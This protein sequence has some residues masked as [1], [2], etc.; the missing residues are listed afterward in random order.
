MKKIIPYVLLTTL[1]ACQNKAPETVMSKTLT[2]KDSSELSIPIVGSRDTIN[3]TVADGLKQGHWIEFK[4]SM[5]LGGPKVR[6]GN[7]KNSK[8]IGEWL[9]YGERQILKS[10]T[11]YV[12]DKPIGY[13]VCYDKDGNITKEG[14]YVDG[15]FVEKVK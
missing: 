7:Y 5:K 11:T 12:N 14:N 4:D 9:G 10:K 13:A 15:V 3:F 1:Y 2:S 6:E 8:K